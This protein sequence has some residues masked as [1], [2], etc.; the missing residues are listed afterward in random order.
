MKVAM[1][2]DDPGY[3]G[4]AE[5]TMR[6]FAN[7]APDEVE[8]VPLDEAETVVVGNCWLIGE[9]ERAMLRG[10]RV[11]RFIHDERGPGP[12]DSDERVFYSPLQRDHVGLDGQLCPAPI[13]LSQF[14]PT[15][16][17]RRH[18]KGAC[19]IGTWNHPGKG[20][21]RIVEWASQ[22]P[23]DR[24]LDVYG[25]GSFIPRGAGIEYCG[26]LDP[27]AVPTTLWKYETFVHLPTQ[28]EGYGRGVVEAWAAGCALLINGNVG[29]AYWI[30]HEPAALDD[31]ADRFWRL[32]LR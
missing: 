23:P 10:K 20:Q 5:L 25:F 12:I 1:L 17:T 3:V 32:I 30:E 29:S 9:P 8:L 14:H 27:S 31:P 7:A 24:K 26:E 16:Q 15:R 6:E 19:S 28:I 11:I 13:D 4:G 2:A 21:E 18:R 22:L